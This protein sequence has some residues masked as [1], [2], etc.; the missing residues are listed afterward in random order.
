MAISLSPHQGRASC[1]PNAMRKSLRR[2]RKEDVFALRDVELFFSFC[3]KLLQIHVIVFFVCSLDLFPFQAS[4]LLFVV[5]LDF[6][7]W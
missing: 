2:R 1:L 5:S 4:F 7:A 3:L 6:P